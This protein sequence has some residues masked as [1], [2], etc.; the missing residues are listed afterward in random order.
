MS[1]PTRC[2]NPLPQALS[3]S[4]GCRCR[5]IGFDTVQSHTTG[6]FF[7]RTGFEILTIPFLTKLASTPLL[8]TAKPMR[9]LEGWIIL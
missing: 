7:D 9:I 4:Q 5:G 2:L 8:L 1:A 3:T 6:P